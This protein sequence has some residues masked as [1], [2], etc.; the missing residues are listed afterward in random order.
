MSGM[1]WKSTSSCSWEYLVCVRGLGFKSY[2]CYFFCD[3]KL[4]LFLCILNVWWIFMIIELYWLVWNM[5]WVNWLGIEL[6]CTWV[7]VQIL[8][9]LNETLFLPFFLVWFE[10]EGLRETLAETTVKGSWKNKAISE[11]EWSLP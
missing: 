10:V 2:V 3:I 8:E 4:V 6:V 1:T 5:N 7:W 11:L 9:D